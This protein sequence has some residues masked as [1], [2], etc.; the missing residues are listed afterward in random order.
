MGSGQ[1]KGTEY[2]ESNDTLRGLGN[3]DEYQT[4]M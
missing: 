2:G 3:L 1:K 4:H